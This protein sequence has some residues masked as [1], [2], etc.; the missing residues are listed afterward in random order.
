MTSHAA[1]AVTAAACEV[2][3]GPCS[4]PFRPH[5]PE[6]Y[7][8]MTPDHRAQLAAVEAPESP[9]VDPGASRGRRR[10]EN[11]MAV[12]ESRPRRTEDRSC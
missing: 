10:G 12:A 2:C 8:F 3:G 6:G 9:P 11:R 5:V 4:E 1:L 7:P